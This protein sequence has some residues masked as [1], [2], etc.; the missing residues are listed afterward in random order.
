MKCEKLYYKRVR[1]RGNEEERAGKLV[2]EEIPESF[3]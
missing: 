1:L 2:L 3:I